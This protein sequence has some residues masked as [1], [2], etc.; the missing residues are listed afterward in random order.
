MIALQK[1]ALA[2]P[3]THKVLHAVWGFGREINKAPE[4]LE[5]SGACFQSDV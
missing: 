1:R 2:Q 3:K 5:N 4:F